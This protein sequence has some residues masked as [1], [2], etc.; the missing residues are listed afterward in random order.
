MIY[1]DHLIPVHTSVRSAL[2][3]LDVLSSNAVVFLVDENDQLQ[4]ALTDGDIR[5]GLIK[6]LDM[7]SPLMDFAN[8]N[9]KRIE[10][11][12][13]DIHQ[14][15]AYRE[16]RFDI[17]PVVDADMRVINVVN[18]REQRSYLPVDAV[19]MAGGKG[20]RLRPLTEKTPKPLLPVGGRPILEH[21]IDRLS[22]FG[23]DDIWISLHY[24]GEQIEA[25]F[26]NGNQR[27]MRIQY[28]WEQ[29]PL[30]TFGAVK[31]IDNFLHD[32][33]LVT[34]SDLLT[35]LD[36]EDFFLDFLDK[37][38]DMAVVTI[39]Y[40]VKVPYAVMETSN[41]HVISFK[42]KPTYT[43]YSNGGIYLLKRELLAHI[44]AHTP[45]NATDLM[46]QVIADGGRL[47][48]FPMRDYWLDIGRPEDYHR[49]QED[50]KHLKI[51]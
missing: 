34:N 27:N 42:E 16:K 19:I 30:G 11:Q 13:Y 22:Q 46:E 36:Y 48:S 39:P 40:E 20:T 3:K 25:Y 8:P 31:L 41:H 12:R 32:Y 7:Q 17:L 38:A 24:L 4:G 50:I 2:E 49:A 47:L 35:T 18:L 28:V 23:V 21:N 14:I 5:R 37:G 1:R 29:E 10:K 43:Y 33:I 9:P 26:G 45:Y 6:G 44:P 51:K 15:I